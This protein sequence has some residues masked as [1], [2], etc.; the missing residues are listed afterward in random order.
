MLERRF[1][2]AAGTSAQLVFAADGDGTLADAD[3]AA[4][5][6]AALADVAGQPD[7]GAVGELQTQRRRPHRLRRR[8]VR[9]ALRGH[10]R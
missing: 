5:I 10:P 6:D 1:P 9:P 7:V 8:P 3:A 2:A 4:A